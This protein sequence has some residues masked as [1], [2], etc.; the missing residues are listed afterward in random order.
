MKAALIAVIVLALIAAPWVRAHF[1]D[2]AFERAV[3][4]LAETPGSLAGADAESTTQRVRDL[5]SDRGIKIP[6]DGVK[7]VTRTSPGG[8]EQLT[9]VSVQYERPIYLGLSK[10]VRFEIAVVAPPP[11]AK[12]QPAPAVADAAVEASVPIDAGT[13]VGCAG[14]APPTR[15][16]LASQGYELVCSLV[17]GKPDGFYQQY[18]QTHQLRLRGFYDEGMKKGLWTSWRNNGVRESE[19]EYF[20]DQKS[21]L[22]TQYDASGAKLVVGHW[23]AGKKHGLW[24]EYAPNGTLFRESNY[25][26]GQLNGRE[27]IYADDG[28]RLSEGQFVDD[29]K[30]GHWVH[31]F[32]NGNKAAEGDFDQGNEVGVWRIWDENGQEQPARRFEQ[33]KVTLVEG[34]RCPAGTVARRSEGTSLR[35]T[36]CERTTGETTRTGRSS[37]QTTRTLR[38]GPTVAFYGDGTK[39]FEGQYADNSKDGRWTYYRPDGQVSRQET[40][41]HGVLLQESYSR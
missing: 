25:Q 7:P 35:E 32:R 2:L 20:E 40:W 5:A 28:T 10:A 14:G 27:T 13:A 8:A 41:R 24:E 1:A 15:R 26:R 11:A 6:P 23:R 16:D 22:E 19:I 29:K 37:F 18:D 12:S 3:S 36:W 9:G 17:A 21:G 33:G 34:T 38:H 31:F 39:F 30:S 4:E